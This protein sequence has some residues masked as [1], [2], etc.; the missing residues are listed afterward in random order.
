MEPYIGQ[1]CIAAFNF[2]PPGW[3]VCNGAL[4]N[5]AQNQALYALLG[6]NFGGD[7]KT[8]FAL[9]DLRG[10]SPVG[11]SGFAT[12]PPTTVTPYRLGDKGGAE[13]VA[14]TA[15]TTPMH[16]HTLAASTNKGTVGVNG[17]IFAEQTLP[18]GG[19]ANLYAPA[20][21]PTV[22][23]SNPVSTAGAGQGHD[24]MQPSLVLNYLIATTGTFPQRP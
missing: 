10:R 6:T 8:T 2:A 11:A 15:N 20:S 23:L 22:I 16:A 12:S 3:A 4:L 7:G 21:T 17:N 9:P 5:I 1:L 14:L 19:T 24:N 18:S 13:T